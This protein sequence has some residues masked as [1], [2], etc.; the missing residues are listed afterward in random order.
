MNASMLEKGQSGVR[1]MQATY[2][3]VDAVDGG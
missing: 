1:N 3:R 2:R